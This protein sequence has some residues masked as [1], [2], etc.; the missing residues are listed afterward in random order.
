MVQIGVQS[1]KCKQCVML[2]LVQKR[3]AKIG[4]WLGRM[5]AESSLNW[6]AK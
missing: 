6:F 2:F 4:S 3:C 5:S 1:L